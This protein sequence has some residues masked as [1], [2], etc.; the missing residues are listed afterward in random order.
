MR[1]RCIP[2]NGVTQ[3]ASNTADVSIS[4]SC[5]CIAENEPRIRRCNICR[6]IG[7]A[8]YNAT[9]TVPNRIAFTTHLHHLTESH[10]V[11]CPN[12]VWSRNPIAFGPRTQS[13]S[14]PEPNRIRAQNPIAFGPRTQSHTGPEPNGI[15]AQNPIAFCCL[16][17]NSVSLTQNLPVL[18]LC[19]L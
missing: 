7:Q 15:R 2:A 9:P 3:Q 14:G 16:V 17:A 18:D 1:G 19:H 4:L 13:H 8:G 6:V 5:H 12:L 11:P 10:F